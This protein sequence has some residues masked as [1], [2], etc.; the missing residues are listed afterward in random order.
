M[1]ARSRSPASPPPISDIA[2]A[3]PVP[4]P[5]IVAIALPIAAARIADDGNDATLEMRVREAVEDVTEAMGLEIP[6][7]R[8]GSAT[9]EAPETGVVK[10][11]PSDFFPVPA[12][13]T[14]E[15]PAGAG[16]VDPDF[17][18]PDSPD[19]TRINPDLPRI[20]LPGGIVDAPPI[21]PVGTEPPIGT[22][23]E[24]SPEEGAPGADDSASVDKE[25]PSA[26]PG[27]A[28]LLA[29]SSEETTD[30]EKPGLIDENET[31]LESGALSESDS[32]Q[33]ENDHEEPDCTSLEVALINTGE[34][35]EGA[36]KNLKKL[37]D[38]QK[39]AAKAHKR[40]SEDFRM[41]LI[42]ATVSIAC[43]VALALTTG[44]LSMW[45]K[46]RG[47]LAS[48]LNQSPSIFSKHAAAKS[49]EAAYDRLNKAIKVSKEFLN[50]EQRE[51]DRLK[52]KYDQCTNGKKS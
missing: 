34:V 51:Y 42:Q 39:D 16:G 47:L 2:I 18:R 4:F 40:S 11:Q 21:S 8:E 23:E 45:L 5:R 37:G 50:D 13:D 31:L 41:A 17:N 38:E 27:S 33:E 32:T 26:A 24:P 19:G 6:K 52:E 25:T 1:P 9:Q 46:A 22:G 12:T 3:R 30:E 20:D 49:T 36:K 15:P 35:I 10:T 28:S 43:D 29:E 48:T 14:P 7:D 44:G